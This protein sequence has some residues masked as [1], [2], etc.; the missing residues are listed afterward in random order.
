M[1]D[2]DKRQLVKKGALTTKAGLFEARDLVHA[3]THDDYTFAK[4]EEPA[5][6]TTVVHQE[7]TTKAQQ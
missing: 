6:C 7:I 3:S 1:V 2:P 5:Y 4:R